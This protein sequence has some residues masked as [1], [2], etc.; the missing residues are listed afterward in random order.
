MSSRQHLGPA[1]EWAAGRE[2]LELEVLARL[3]QVPVTSMAIAVLTLTTIPAL[4]GFVCVRRHVDRML[5]R[6]LRDI[7]GLG[8]IQETFRICR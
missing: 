3:G 5:R 8:D 2:G 4:R 1:V 7:Q 6:C